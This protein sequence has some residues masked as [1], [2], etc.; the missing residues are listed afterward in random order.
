M[1]LIV[2]YG[3]QIHTSVH[4]YIQPDVPIESLRLQAELDVAEAELKAARLR[5][6]YVEAKERAKSREKSQA[7]LHGYGTHDSPQSRPY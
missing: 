3:L 7:S 4:R 5:L 6:L 2:R 1:P